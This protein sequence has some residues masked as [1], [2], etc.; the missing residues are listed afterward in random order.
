MSRSVINGTAIQEKA[1]RGGNRDDHIEPA[2]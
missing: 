1:W 2:A